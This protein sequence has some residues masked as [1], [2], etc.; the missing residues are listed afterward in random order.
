[1]RAHNIIAIITVAA[2]CAGGYFAY[3]SVRQRLDP[4]GPLLA[5]CENSLKE[6]LKAPSTYERVED[7]LVV[8]DEATPEEAMPILPSEAEDEG[9]RDARERMRQVYRQSG[10][11]KH[12]A[13]IRYESANSFGA[14]IAGLSTCDYFSYQETPP[15]T[16][17]L[18]HARIL[19]DGKTNF[20]RALEGVEAFLR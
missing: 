15:T 18:R 9:L 11:F 20:D 17:D 14:P 12:T 2:I 5:A 16:D 10:A 3:P 19:I 4:H 6:R 8:V 7:P 1:M 13:F